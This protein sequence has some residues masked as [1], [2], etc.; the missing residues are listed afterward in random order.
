[1]QP[2]PLSKNNNAE[3]QDPG[4]KAVFYIS[5]G[6]SERKI[7]DDKIMIYD[8]AVAVINGFVDANHKAG[9]SVVSS[10]LGI[11]FSDDIG[12]DPDNKY[13]LFDKIKNV[14]FRAYYYIYEGNL[15]P[16]MHLN[17]I[18]KL[19]NVAGGI[20]LYRNGFRVL[21]YGEPGDDWLSLDMSTRRRS[22]L[23]THTNISFFGFVEI[24]NQEQDLFIP[25]KNVNGALNGD[26][27]RVSII[28][29]KEG[30]RKAEAKIIKIVKNMEKIFFFIEISPKICYYVLDMILLY[31]NTL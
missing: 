7:V 1:M 18:R 4:F 13:S 16:K 10:K 28:K 24:E 6:F 8:H 29:P 3:G 25:A 21:P 30:N 31:H 11:D 20:R 2:F 5:D 19:A 14:K 26:T 17:A 27:V 9:Y 15:I 12:I 23:P 22:I